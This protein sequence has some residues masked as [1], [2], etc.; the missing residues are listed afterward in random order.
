MSHYPQQLGDTSFSK[1]VDLSPND[2][3]CPWTPDD[4]TDTTIANALA[5][6]TRALPFLGRAGLDS[7][8][9]ESD[10]KGGRKSSVNLH[11]VDLNS[12]K[13][14][15]KAVTSDEYTEEGAGEILEEWDG[16]LS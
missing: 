7:V 6:V 2:C 13:H 12:K 11:Y 9:K 15:G 5:T 14:K 8:G 3:K 1:H 16:V 10:G 4:P